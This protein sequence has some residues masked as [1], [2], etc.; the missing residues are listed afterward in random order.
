MGKTCHEICV[1]RIEARSRVRRSAAGDGGGGSGETGEDGNHRRM[2]P[3]A[4]IFL[5][6]IRIYQHT[7]S[8]LIG[9]SCRHQP[10]CSRY[11]AEAILKYGAV[12]GGWM[13]FKRVCRCNPWGTSGY[14]P[15]E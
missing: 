8:H 4:W 5:L 11:G 10:T 6:I 9:G 1:K 13:T 12:K 7:L 14:D 3:L 2:S 15:V